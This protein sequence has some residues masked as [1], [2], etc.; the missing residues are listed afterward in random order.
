MV[1]VV[2]LLDDVD[3]VV[4]VVVGSIKEVATQEIACADESIISLVTLALSNGVTLSGFTT[5]I[6]LLLS[7]MYIKH[8][9]W[10]IDVGTILE[11]IFK[12]NSITPV[13]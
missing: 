1:V 8:S 13:A 6:L 5:Y 11:P 4:V 7:V 3:V 12:S 10:N 2:V 9:H